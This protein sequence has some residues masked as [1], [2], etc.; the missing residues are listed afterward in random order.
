MYVVDRNLQPA[1]IGVP[2][3]LLIGGDGVTD[4]Y[5][6]RPELT[7]DRFILDHFRPDVPGARLYRTG[8]LVRV[9]SD[10]RFEFL[11]RLDFQVKL[12]GYRIELGEIETRLAE[13][14]LVREAVVVAREDVPGDQRLVAYVIPA[15][16]EIDSSAL[17]DHLGEK[18]PEFMVPAHY[19]TVDSYPLTPNNKTDR[20][21]LPPPVEHLAAPRAVYAPPTNAAEQQLVA[22]WCELLGLDDVGVNDNFFDLG[23]HSLLAVQLHRSIVQALDASISITD[24]FRFPTIASLAD[25]VE[26][27][28]VKVEQAQ[29]QVADRAATRRKA[30]ASRRTR[31]RG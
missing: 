28:G 31:R 6:E 12:R 24:V 11:G 18:L 2:G 8:D 9:G 30:M 7:D 16:G 1:P 10:G 3:E 22:I 27:Q 5:F 15:A 23:G 21:A 14:P 13:H 29:Q 4:G 26:H 25:H 17:R 20:R 19:V